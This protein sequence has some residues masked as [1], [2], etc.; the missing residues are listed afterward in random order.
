MSPQQTPKDRTLLS[1]QVS[2][3]HPRGSRAR[4]CNVR[5]SGL[6]PLSF[7]PHP[8]CTH[9]NSSSAGV[10]LIQV[11]LFRA[12][13]TLRLPPFSFPP[14]FT[15]FSLELPSN[16]GRVE[17]SWSMRTLVLIIRFSPRLLGQKARAIRCGGGWGTVGVRWFVTN[18]NY[19]N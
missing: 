3:H 8:L 11:V 13:A 2:A 4:M 12:V 6:V 16:K 1:L 5:I 7:H 15:S 14:V 17:N 9:S 10:P 19:P 18:A